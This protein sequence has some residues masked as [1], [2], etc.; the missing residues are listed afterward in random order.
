MRL[1]LLLVVAIAM[2]CVPA[3]LAADKTRTTVK[4]NSIVLGGGQTSW[5]GPISSPKKGC[6]N[7]RRV[8]VF[9]VRP[10]KDEKRGSTKSYK[11]LVAKGYF[12][13]YSEQGAAPTGQYYAKVKPTDVCKG[14]KS[15]T[16][17]GPSF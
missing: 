8:L 15:A 2:A 14:D 1:A 10:G 6:K 3:A 9:R 7:N 11:G 17:F 5:G 13:S 12:W 16:V 4:L